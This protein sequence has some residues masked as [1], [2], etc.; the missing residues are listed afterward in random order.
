VFVI[1]HRK[2]QPQVILYI[3]DMDAAADEAQRAIYRRMSV[4]AKLL[5]SQSLREF[6]WQL[7]RSAI[8]RRHP[9]LNEGEVLDQ[10]RASFADGAA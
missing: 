8:R 7:K 6:A 4:E 10:V 3:V 9:E 1:G 5:A 2:R